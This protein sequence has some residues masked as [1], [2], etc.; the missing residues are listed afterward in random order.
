MAGSLL[1]I[2]YKRRELFTQSLRKETIDQ[3]INQKRR[4]FMGLSDVVYSEKDLIDACI[5]LDDCHRNELDADSVLKAVKKLQ[6][7]TT[8]V[9]GESSALTDKHLEILM[10]SRAIQHINDIMSPIHVNDAE[11]QQQATWIVIN[12][13]T[14][15]DTLKRL[16]TSGVIASLVTLIDNSDDIEVLKN[17]LWALRNAL[18]GSSDMRD[19]LLQKDFWSMVNYRLEVLGNASGGKNMSETDLEKFQELVEEVIHIAASFVK[20]KPH[21]SFKAVGELSLVPSAGESPHHGLE[22]RQGTNQAASSDWDE[23]HNLHNAARADA[24][25]AGAGCGHRDD[26]H[27]ALP[28]YQQGLEAHVSHYPHQPQCSRRLR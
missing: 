9:M 22:A 8:G 10:D 7:V 3:I 24:P 1:R 6:E 13:F 2:M 27:P 23:A 28:R 5:S 15:S 25:A 11:L 14:A 12:A 19:Y 26:G 18:I 20:V 21:L 4:K 16:Q 17:C